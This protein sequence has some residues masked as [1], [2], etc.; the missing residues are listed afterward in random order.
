LASIPLLSADLDRKTPAS[1]AVKFAKEDALPGAQNQLAVSDYELLAAADK[2]TFAVSVGIAFI[3]PVSRAKMRHK[4]FQ[5]QQYIVDDGGVCVFV[6]GNA[7]GSMGAIY[8]GVAFFDA[9]L[10]DK[11]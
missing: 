2:R 3:V 8:Y 4:L 9:G 1:R 7:C 10:T 5:G 6:Y 11:R